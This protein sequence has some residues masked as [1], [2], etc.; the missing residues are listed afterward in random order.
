MIHSAEDLDAAFQAMQTS[1][2]D[3]V[4]VQPSLPTKRVA[5]LALSHR[6][7][8]ICTF[9]DFA[10]AGGLMAYFAEHR[11]PLDPRRCS[12]VSILRSRTK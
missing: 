12:C 8:A 10:Y 6:I 9:R 1:R 11:V 2:A 4:I 5:E 7:P 3:A